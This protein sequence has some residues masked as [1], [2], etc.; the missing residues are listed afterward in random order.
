[1]ADRESAEVKRRLL[2]ELDSARVDLQAHG[3]LAREELSPKALVS[4]SLAQNKVAWII[5]GTA[6]GL[7]LVRVLFPPK[8]KSDNSCYSYKTGWLSRLFQSVTSTV[9]KRAASQLASHYLKD[10]A[11]NYLTSFFQRT[12]SPEK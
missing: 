12:R 2:R 4:K 7:L 8:I 5:A 11:Q 6:A 1:M 3:Q 9:V 10:S